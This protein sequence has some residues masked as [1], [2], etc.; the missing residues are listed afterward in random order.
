MKRIPKLKW[1]KISRQFDVICLAFFKVIAYNVI[2]K[3]KEISKGKE[4]KM[5]ITVFENGKA[6]EKEITYAEFKKMME[7]TEVVWR[8][9]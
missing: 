9:K 3:V 2:H 1:L 5:K 7:K 4:N 6:V 8:N